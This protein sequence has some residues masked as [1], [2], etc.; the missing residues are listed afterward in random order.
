MFTILKNLIAWWPI[1]KKDVDYDA[2][3]LYPILQ[4]KLTQLRKSLCKAPVV[5]IDEEIVRIIECIE[6]C[7]QLEEDDFC[8]EEYAKHDEKYGKLELISKENNNSKLIECD[9]IRDKADTDELKQKESE[10]FKEIAKLEDKRR[11]RA[12]LKLFLTIANNHRKWWY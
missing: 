12:I 8:K 6:L 4:F 5:G 10:E 7:K 9:L 3:S 1:I 11:Q 2:T